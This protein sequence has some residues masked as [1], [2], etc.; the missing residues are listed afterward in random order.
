MM[1][2]NDEIRKLIM[3][4]ADAVVLTAGRAPQR[5][6]QSPRRRLDEGPRRRDHR[7]GSHARDAGILAAVATHFYFRAVASDGKVRTGVS[8]ARPRSWSPANCASRGSRPSMSASSRRSRSSSS[9]R[10][11][12]AAGGA[13]SSSSPRSSR[14]CST[15]ACRSTAPYRSRANSPNAPAFRPSFSSLRVL[16][17]GKS[18]ADSLGDA[19]GL[20]LRPLR[21][22]GARGRSIG[23]ARG[24]LRTSRR[25]R[26]HARRSAQLHHLV[27]DLPGAAGQRRHGIRSSFC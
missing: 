1:E 6:A 8:R 20:L 11:S 4:N 24:R 13:T 25:I 14:R 15:P 21:Q 7:R 5:H 16:K 22:H 10:P 3:A 23:L 18:L 27:D 9:C 26:T 12:T 2:L 19:S 17:G